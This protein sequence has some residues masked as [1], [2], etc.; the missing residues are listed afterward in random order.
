MHR[1]CHNGIFSIPSPPVYRETTGG[2]VRGQA[3]RV[4]RHFVDA[5]G[6]A[7]PVGEEWVFLGGTFN[8]F[9]DEVG[10]WVRL[11]SGEEWNLPSIWTPDKQQGVIEHLREYVA[12]VGRRY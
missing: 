2:L 7:H 6:D 10:I 9:E 12:E 11:A 1:L 3:Y 4:T 8:K 5:E